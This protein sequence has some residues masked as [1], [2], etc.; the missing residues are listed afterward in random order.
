MK[1][2]QIQIQSS[3]SGDSARPS[4]W[5]YTKKDLEAH[6]KRLATHAPLPAAA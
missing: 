1:L 3:R 2:G 4:N 5:R 6:L